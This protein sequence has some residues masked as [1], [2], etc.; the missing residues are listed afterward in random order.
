MTEEE[1][2]AEELQRRG[3]AEAWNRLYESV[4][5]GQTIVLA[6][7]EIQRIVQIGGERLILYLESVTN[8]RRKK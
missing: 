1:I 5:K 6:S 2:S 8:W 4:E 7:E 3:K